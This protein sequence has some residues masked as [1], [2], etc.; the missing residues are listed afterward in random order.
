MWRKK[1]ST[2]EKRKWEK[3]TIRHLPEY[4]KQKHPRCARESDH[5]STRTIA[6]HCI[7]LYPP[8]SRLIFLHG[9]N[10]CQNPLLIAREHEKTTTTFYA[11][12]Q[13]N[14]DHFSL[15]H[16]WAKS[17]FECA[18]SFGEVVF[19]IAELCQ[20]QILHPNPVKETIWLDETEKMELLKRRNKIE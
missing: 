11:L 12:I 17:L 14:P 13:S 2:K 6:P 5:H 3:Y 19:C 1:K 15:P 20:N 18:I 4:H 10:Y 9:P 8:L 7:V 16:E